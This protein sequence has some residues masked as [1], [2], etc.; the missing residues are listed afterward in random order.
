MLTNSGEYILRT[1]YHLFSIT[2]MK[3]LFEGEPLA[4]IT[5]R[6]SVY[7]S[8]YNSFQFLYRL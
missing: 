7:V 8:L 5:L 1:E 2:R 6:L 4:V 3:L